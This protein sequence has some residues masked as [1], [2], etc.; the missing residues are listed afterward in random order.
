MYPAPKEATRGPALLEE[1]KHA[2]W[3]EGSVN[4]LEKRGSVCAL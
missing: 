4:A 1:R 3:A 2:R